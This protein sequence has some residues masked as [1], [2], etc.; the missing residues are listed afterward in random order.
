[1]SGSVPIE[2]SNYIIILDGV[3]EAALVAG[4]LRGVLGG[5][6][7]RRGGGR[8]PSRDEGEEGE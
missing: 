1:M 8:P 2:N 6:G 4:G 5:G 7:T 3:K